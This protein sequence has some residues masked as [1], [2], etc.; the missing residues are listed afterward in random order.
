MEDRLPPFL[1]FMLDGPLE[2]SMKNLNWLTGWRDWCFAGYLARAGRTVS[3]LE[4]MSLSTSV[5][6]HH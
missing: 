1:V 3:L 2:T 6:T 4:S 5:L